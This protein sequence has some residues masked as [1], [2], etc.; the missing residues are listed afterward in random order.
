[1]NKMLLFFRIGEN[2]KKVANEIEKPANIK[3]PS[4][5]S[6]TKSSLPVDKYDNIMA[7]I[8]GKRVNTI[9]SKNQ[10]I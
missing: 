8:N 10:L 9:D 1:M 4:L 7:A 3:S 5:Q 2:L 6:L